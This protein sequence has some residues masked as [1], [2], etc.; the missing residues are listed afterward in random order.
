[1]LR[2][3]TRSVRCVFGKDDVDRNLRRICVLLI[4]VAVRVR[5]LILLTKPLPSCHQRPS[6]L[7]SASQHPYLDPHR[8]AQSR[9]ADSDYPLS[10]VIS[11]VQPAQR[12]QAH[13][14]VLLERSALE[15]VLTTT[16]RQESY[17]QMAPAQT[18]GALQVRATRTTSSPPLNNLAVSGG[19][20]A[21]DHHALGSQNLFHSRKRKKI[22]DSQAPLVIPAKPNPDW[23]E[24][25]RRRRAAC[26]RTQPRAPSFVPVSA[27][28]ATG[29][30]GSVGGLGTRD[31]INSGPQLSGLQ[32]KTPLESEVS[33]TDDVMAETV[34]TAVPVDQSA[35]ESIEETEDQKALR[36]ILAGEDG[37]APL[38]EI[39]PVPPLSEEDALRQDV[40]DLPDAATADDYERVPISAFG[41][42][43][44]RG[45]GWTDG[46]VAP[47]SDKRRKNA[48]R[49]LYLPQ[50]R[51][52]LLGIGAKEQEPDDDGTGKKKSKRP[53]MRYVPIARKVSEKG[54]NSRSSTASGRSLHSPSR[55]ER[56][57]RVS[58]R[59]RGHARHAD[60]GR[61]RTDRDDRPR[62]RRDHRDR[63][64]DRVVEKGRSGSRGDRYHDRERHEEGKR[65]DQRDRTREPG[66]SRR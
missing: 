20:L 2:A 27:L 1:M 9:T 60:R 22:P 62:E 23:R 36:A 58:D 63:D 45:M 31:T 49:D 13:L 28:A 43:M 18:T 37:P 32:F 5:V 53:D 39:I 19:S 48:L 42:A 7:R 26:A 8:L 54:E 10:L 35:V 51:P 4:A 24:A 50:A 61:R 17:L 38:V 59:E 40:Q 6:R 41:A 57:D 25:A 16:E 65:F 47:K 11:P 33:E 44:L 56:E 3:C 52:A 46:A 55:Q 29:A 30:D 21:C 64:R 12:P 66:T 15:N 34:S 14:R